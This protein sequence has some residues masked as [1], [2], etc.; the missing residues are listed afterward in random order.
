MNAKRTNAK[1]DVEIAIEEYE[2]EGGSLTTGP[3]QLPA[4]SIQVAQS[5]PKV[6]YQLLKNPYVS[7][8]G[9]SCLFEGGRQLVIWV[10]GG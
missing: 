5:E 6:V 8:V 10:F 9:A 3:Q 1:R 2:N 4:S 7:G